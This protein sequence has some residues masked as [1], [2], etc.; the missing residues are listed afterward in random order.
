MLISWETLPQF[1]FLLLPIS[2]KLGES[3]VRD[4]GW[5]RDVAENSTLTCPYLPCTHV[6][7]RKASISLRP[8][9][10]GLCATVDTSHR[11]WVPQL[12][13]SPKWSVCLSEGLTTAGNSHIVEGR[14]KPVHLDSHK[15]WVNQLLHLKSTVLTH[16]EMDWI[17]FG[18]RKHTHVW[19][20]NHVKRIW[21]VYSHS[22]S[23]LHLA[24]ALYELSKWF[25]RCMRVLA[26][27]H[28]CEKVF[29]SGASWGESA[30]HCARTDLEGHICFQTH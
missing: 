11:D 6:M 7:S 27:A 28:A 21:N 8:V 9:A 23:Y 3:E 26:P 14:R 20:E 10:A 15:V 2:D 29:I 5:C 17:V 16:L 22:L 13:H 25:H 18:T 19:H 30:S 24:L 12:A 4:T 1:T